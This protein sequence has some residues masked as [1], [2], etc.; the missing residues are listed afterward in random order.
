MKYT[1]KQIFMLNLQ[2]HQGKQL[3][4]PPPPTPSYLQKLSDHCQLGE[5][6]LGRN[7][8]RVVGMK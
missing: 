1:N 4:P 5:I 8:L 2:R 3:C 7:H 6:S